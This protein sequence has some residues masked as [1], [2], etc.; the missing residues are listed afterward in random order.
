MALDRMQVANE[1]DRDIQCYGK[2][3]LDPSWTRA[4]KAAFAIGFSGNAKDGLPLLLA[5]MKP[6]AAMNAERFPVHQAI[7][8]SL[9]RL[10]TKDCAECVDKLEKQIERDE[11]AVRIPGARDLLGETRVTLAI[12]QNR[13]TKDIMAQNSP[14]SDDAAAAEPMPSGKGKKGC[15]GAQGR[16][17]REEAPLQLARLSLCPLLKSPPPVC[18]RRVRERGR[19]APL[20]PVFR[21][22][23]RVDPAAHLELA[24]DARASGRDRRHQVVEDPV[25]DRLV[26]R[27]LVAVRPEVELPRL[28]LDAELSGTYSTRMVAKSGWPVLGHRQ[29]NS[30]HSNLIR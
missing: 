15:E 20:L 22:D 19:R 11:K 3:L 23:R 17:A 18:G 4:E 16:Q 29:V 5:A 27:A 6:I 13:D 1:C 21:D 26:E 25:R 28:E 30:G 7:L 8:F 14:A 10:G 12:I 24:L 9:S 2:K